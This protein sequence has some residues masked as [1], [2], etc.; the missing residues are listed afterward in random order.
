MA[1]P[2]FF[3]IGAPKCGTTALSEYLRQH[4]SIYF[5]NP[6]EPQ[7]FCKDFPG[8][9]SVETDQEYIR[10]YFGRS[11]RKR[12]RAIGEGSVWYLYSKVAVENILQFNKKAK[13]IVM[14]RNPIEMVYSLHNQMLFTANEDIEDFEKAWHMQT[15]RAQGKN[16]PKSC[17]EP[18][19]LQY[20]EVGKLGKQMER[21]FR[22]VPREQRLVILFDDFA[23]HTRMIYKNV[24]TFLEVEDDGRQDFPKINENRVYT[25]KWAMHFTQRP[26]QILV[27][28]ADRLK[29]VLGV[30]TLNLMSIIQ[31]YTT[32]NRPRPP[33]SPEMVQI[34]TDTFSED[35]KKLAKLLNRDITHW[36]RKP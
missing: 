12:Y 26:P 35:V 10:R 3:I 17:I 31:K 15:L 33:L 5:S 2:N 6:K 13:F 30:G 29:K 36:L 18:Q 8:Y 4:K 28:L 16:I 11:D 32:K 25:N 34:M 20:A 14:L 22:I 27:Q 21:F 9:K 23:R 7:Y 24:L 19:F 1:K